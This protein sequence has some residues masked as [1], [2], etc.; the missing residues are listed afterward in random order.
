MSKSELC[1]L[2]FLIFYSPLPF[3]VPA[4]VSETFEY[5]EI[6]EGFHIIQSNK[7]LKN[8]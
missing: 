3:G 8:H 4:V 2:V 5:A 6:F 1:F 7:E